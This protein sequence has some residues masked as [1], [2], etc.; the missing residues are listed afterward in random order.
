[1]YFGWK[2]FF[3]WDTPMLDPAK[4]MALKPVPLMVSYQ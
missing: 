4:T 3:T 2:N 1:V